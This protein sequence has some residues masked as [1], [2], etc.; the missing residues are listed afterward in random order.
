MISQSGTKRK[1]IDFRTSVHRCLACSEEFIP[2]QHQRLDKHFHNL[3]SWIIF[4]HVVYRI[5][6]ETII[7]MVTDFFAIHI[8]RQEVHMFKRTGCKLI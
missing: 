4:H 3:K 8:S 7:R 1:I 6:M 2:H 5:P